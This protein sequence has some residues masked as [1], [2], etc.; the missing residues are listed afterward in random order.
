MKMKRSREWLFAQIF[1]LIISIGIF[2]PLAV[3]AAGNSYRLPE[4]GLEITIPTEY[5]VITKDTLASDAIFSRLG[6]TKTEVIAQLQASGIYLNAV[7]DTRNEEIVVT[8]IESEISNFSLLS[9]S[10][11]MAFAST[12]IGEAAEY[13]IYVSEYEVYQH[14]QAKFLCAH[15]TDAA[16]TVHGLQYYTVYNGKAINF[17]MRSYEGVLSSVQRG[18]IKMVV[19]SVKFDETAPTSSS[20]EDTEPFVHVDT[21][22]GVTFIV[23]AN[24]KQKAFT[25]EREFIDVK[26]VSTKDEGCTMIYGSTDMWAKMSAAE[27]VGYTRSDLNNA[28]FTASDIATMYNTTADKISVVTYNGSQYYKGEFTD[29]QEVYD[30]E[31]SITMTRLIRIE[32]GWMYMFQFSGTSAHKLFTD[33]ESLLNSVQY[34]SFD[35]GIG[36]EASHA[37]KNDSLGAIVIS[38]GV[39]VVSAVAIGISRK[40]KTAPASSPNYPPAPEAPNRI[41]PSILCRNCGTALLSDSDFCH[42]CGTRIDKEI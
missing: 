21:D 29:T 26:F 35:E 3:F 14:A 11:L 1:V 42:I 33:F 38:L 2:S 6:M 15:F 40:K 17:T 10:G 13:G 37:G 32:N 31:I 30:L 9:D 5:L 28:T 8:M 39:V 36:G 27:K 12:W 41:A 7:S 18:N 16:K 22:S 23:P 4:L 34:L 19:D 20:G 25:K 24:W